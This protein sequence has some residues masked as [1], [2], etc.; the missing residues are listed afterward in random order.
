M[1]GAAV[2]ASGSWW[3]AQSPGVSVAARACGVGVIATLLFFERRQA[4]SVNRT[5]AGTSPPRTIL[6]FAAGLWLLLLV[7]S[8]SHSEWGTLANAALGILAICLFVMLPNRVIEPERLQGVLAG[9]LGV[10]LAASLAVGF[11]WPAHGYLNERL[12]GLTANPNQLAFYA[13]LLGALVF[14]SH[15]SR[16]LS[17]AALTVGVA[18]LFLT[19][20]RTSSIAFAFLVVALALGHSRYA[21]RLFAAAAVALAL[22][23]ISSPSFFSAANFELLRTNNSR[24]VST[25]E[26]L[27][28]FDA[29]PLL[30][31]GF[32]AIQVTVASSPLQVLAAGGLLGIV[33]LV[34]ASG[35]LVLKSM[36][37]GPVTTSL[38]LAALVHSLGEAWLASTS[39][40]MTLFFCMTWLCVA[41]VENKKKSAGSGRS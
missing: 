19:A 41:T 8:V 1:G 21:R 37:I 12:T 16:A 15:R 31:G 28:I 36:R 10:Y 14:S 17:A 22:I 25:D 29:S 30:G 33:L 35:Y 18:V 27:R 39:G 4:A 2:L 38:T 23:F 34:A 24:S 13:L 6:T 20:S 9:M 26:A 3:A 11:L 5:E 32:N 40:P 7:V